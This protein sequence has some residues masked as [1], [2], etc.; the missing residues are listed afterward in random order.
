MFQF[1]WQ[2]LVTAIFYGF[3]HYAVKKNTIKNMAKLALERN[4]DEFYFHMINSRLEVKISVPLTWYVEFLF[5]RLGNNPILQDG[6]HHELDEQD[7]HTPEQLMMMQNQDLKYITLKLTAE[8]NKIQRL[9]AQLQPLG[10]DVPSKK[11]FVF[12]EDGEKSRND[13]LDEHR[14]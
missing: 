1:F 10:L 6:E 12:D 13:A 4:P 14:L 8:R 2:S 3:S 9:K 11:H 7:Q 5:Q